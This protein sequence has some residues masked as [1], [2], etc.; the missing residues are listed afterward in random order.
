MGRRTKA[1]KEDQRNTKKK[2][3]TSGEIFNCKKNLEPC[4]RLK[5]EGN[6]WENFRLWLLKNSHF[7]EF[8]LCKKTLE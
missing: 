1:Y 4:M 7:A 6:P 8:A 2:K 3:Q 5:H